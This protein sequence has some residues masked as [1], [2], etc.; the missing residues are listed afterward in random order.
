MQTILLHANR[1][2][3]H[4]YIVYVFITVYKKNTYFIYLKTCPLSLPVHDIAILY[5]TITYVD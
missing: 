1:K 5:A 2:H 3:I 4:T